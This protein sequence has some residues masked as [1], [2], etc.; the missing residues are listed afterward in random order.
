MRENRASFLFLFFSY[1]HYN[2]MWWKICHLLF[3]NMLFV[4]DIYNAFDDKVPYLR[5]IHVGMY[6]ITLFC[7]ELKI[8]K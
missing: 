2:N 4:V 8:I 5:L 1:G 6:T 7:H 3:L